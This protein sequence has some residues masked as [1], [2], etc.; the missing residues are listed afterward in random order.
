MGNKMWPI[1]KS[2]H[3]SRQLRARF[4]LLKRFG[5]LSFAV[6]ALLSTAALP[7]NAL[8]AEQKTLFD[9]GVNYFDIAIPGSSTCAAAGAG[10]SSGSSGS[11][12]SGS[13]S[14]SSGLTP[15]YILEQFAIETLKDVAAKKGLP[16]SDAVTQEHVIALVAFMFGEGGDIANSDLFNPLN[17]GL[18]APDLISGTQNGSGIQSFKSFDAGVEATARTIVGSYQS[19]LGDVLTQQASTADQFMSALTYYS[20]Y[21]GNAEWAQASMPPNADSY[22]HERLSLVQQVRSRYADSAGLILGTPAK[23]Q[24]LNLTDKSKLVYKPAGDTSSS[25][26]NTGSGAS[27]GSSSDCTGTAG[28]VV[29]GN[30]VKTAI[31][32]SWP[33]TPHDPPLTPTDA[34]AAAIKQ[35]NPDGLSSA[36]GADC[37]A[38]V[39]TVMR[40]SGVDPNYP[41][42]V[43]GN[44]LA[45]AKQHPEK[46]DVLPAI[47]STSD[48]QPGDILITSEHTFIFV[49]NQGLP[50]GNDQASAS[51]GERMPALGKST[52]TDT[53]G[54]YYSRIRLK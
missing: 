3:L 18:N 10:S 30:I 40:A 13:G 11:D 7:V 29:A 16:A 15:P 28:G 43:T 25:T 12:K 46:Y 39:A 53:N 45:Y 6:C 48:M 52:L 50:Y 32:L 35:Y 20:K 22:Y 33:N 1:A 24:L 27:T 42:K 31:A 51:Q 2:G 47:S 54:T 26:S 41:A 49:G 19:R 8:S 9:Q 44:Q 36:N 38:F 34:Y 23:E 5:Y 37:G 14:W 21:P 4:A 17:S